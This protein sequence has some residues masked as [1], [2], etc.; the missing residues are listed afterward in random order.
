[1]LF[2]ELYI[3]INS[4]ILATFRSGVDLRQAL[5]KICTSMWTKHKS[6][7]LFL[8]SVHD[9]VFGRLEGVGRLD[10][11]HCSWWCQ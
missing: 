4:T 1:M 11:V 6:S 7:Y 2:Q 5:T 9:C 8:N 3:A 10:G